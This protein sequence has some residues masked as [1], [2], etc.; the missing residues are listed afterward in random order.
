MPP[1]GSIPVSVVIPTRNEAANLAACLAPLRPFAQVIVADSA[2]SDGTAEI[3]AGWGAEVLNFRW[4]GA[5]PKK[6]QWGLAHPLV[7]HD[8]VLLLDA[9]E[10]LSPALV[11]EIDALMRA[12]PTKAGYF[13]DGRPSFA[14]RDLRFGAGNRKLCLLDR[15]H[16]AF[17]PGEDLGLPGAWEVEGHYQPR[18]DGPA[19]RLRTPL[20]HRDGKP[21]AAWFDRHN[22][23]SDWV[24]ALERAGRADAW[25]AHDTPG[26]RRLKRLFARAA[27]LR[28]ALAF[29][30]SYVWKL[31]LLDGAAGFHYA[32]A[33]AFYYWQIGLK[34][35]A[36]E[37]H[38]RDGI[39]RPHPGG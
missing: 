27:P 5:Y 18:L 7:R 36:L 13:I 39:A 8:W 23:Y 4:N 14:G 1:A 15:R 34:R 21:L 35:R 22:R 17:P 28:P 24:A 9:D 6:K 33:R 26:R 20:R 3:A 12:G 2:S 30:H 29:L 11:A 38:H 16:A 10:V 37:Q 19:G 31:G 32:L 25:A